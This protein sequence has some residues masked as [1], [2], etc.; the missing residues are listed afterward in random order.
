MFRTFSEVLSGV[1]K[2]PGEHRLNPREILFFLKFVVPVWK[3]GVAVL[4]FTLVSTALNSLT[5]LSSKIIIDF[6]IMENSRDTLTKLLT[7]LHLEGWIQPLAGLLE[8]IDAVVLCLLALGL[9]IGVM[10]IFQRVLT[11]GFQQ[12]ITFNIQTALFDRLLRFPLSLIKEKQVGYLMSRVTTD[13]FHIQHFFSSILP[14]AMTGLFSVLFSLAILFT[15]NRVS[16]LAVLVLIPVWIWINV[17]F[18]TRIRSIGLTEMERNALVSQDMQEVISGVEVIKSHVS[19]KREVERISRR[20]RS[21]F[22][23]RIVSAL[24]SSVSANLMKTVKLFAVLGISW[25]CVREIRLGNMTI[26]DMTALIAYVVFLSGQAS[27]LSNSYLMLQH[28][29]ASMER[30]TEM[31]RIALEF[32]TDKEGGQGFVPQS[33]KGD[34]RFDSV[35]FAYEKGKPVFEG[36]SL[37]AAAGDIVAVTGPS[38]AGKTTLINLLIKFL[39]PDSGTISL[40]GR[41]I[42]DIDTQWLRK[43]IGFVS[44]DIFLFNASAADNIRYGNPSASLEEV[45]DA[46]KKA[47]VHKDITGFENGYDTIVGERGV[48]LSA[49]Q[50]QRISVARA[51]LKDPAILIMDEPSSALD[52]A[53]EKI[54]IGSLKRLVENRTTFII[55][56]KA[57]LYDMADR[58]YK[59]QNS[60]TEIF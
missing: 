23:T 1:L 11:L 29:F 53:S 7:P 12:E 21:L 42:Q 35:S 43:R 20:I 54:L 26:G 17:F 50:R 30:L 51:F 36:V 56:H 10:S 31:F 25:F 52:E 49:G 38:G 22:Q 6:V 19:E 32:E 46:A 24:L 5:P 59:L 55:S 9:M 15:L 33:V 28:V 16:F 58:V 4:L 13:V 3:R 2:K 40:D 44:Q 14:Q 37:A 41:D 34:I 39:K 27:A 57:P 18:G 45:V 48:N 60:C 47:G 8:S